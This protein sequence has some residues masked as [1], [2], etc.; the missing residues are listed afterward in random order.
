MSALAAVADD[1]VAESGWDVAFAR[2]P[3]LASAMAAYLHELSG[4]LAPRSVDAAE[5]TLRQFAVHVATTDP[6]CQT[7]ADVTTAH[8]TSWKHALEHRDPAAGERTASKK[9]VA[10]K[11]QTLR[12]FFEH[13]AHSRPL[14]ASQ[15]TSIVWPI[16]KPKK[17]KTRRRSVAPKAPS[18][19][20]PKE[21]SFE[22]IAVHA[23]TM[24]ATMTAYLEQLSVSHRAT[25]VQSASL[26][27]RHLAGHL[28]ATDPECTSVGAVTRAHIESYKVALAARRGIKTPRVSTTTI[29]HNLGQ[30]RTFFE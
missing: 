16:R 12:R 13:S 9:T 8:L 29:R 26:A 23:P 11:L 2:A 17:P 6:T 7:A 25:S 27:L 10:Y 30:L 19:A 4:R 20:L 14:D 5:L 24:A 18:R 3:M 28:I 21:M 15:E 22:D 1:V